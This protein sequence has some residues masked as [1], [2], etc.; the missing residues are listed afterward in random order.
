MGI[1]RGG[2]SFEV[3]VVLFCGGQGMR[4]REHSQTLPKP[5]V[6]IGDRPLL[7]HL[8]RY[9]AHYGHTEFVLCLG[10]Q[11]ATIRDYFLN[12]D[13]CMSN[14]FTLAPGGRHELHSSDVSDWSISFIDTGLNSNIGQRLLR[15]REYLHGESIFLANYADGLSD[16]PL[17][18]FLEE[19]SRGDAIAA[20]AAVQP[21]RPLAAVYADEAGYVSRIGSIRDGGTLINGGFFAMRPEIFE[22]LN[23]GEELLEQPFARLLAAGRLVAYRHHGFWQSLDTHRDKIIFDRMAAQ[24]ACPWAVW[25]R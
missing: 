24:G 15:A 17:D 20:F 25:R 23:E 14:D 1:G 22:F 16:L 6:R 13:E 9:Y 8:M 11:G 7:W 3:K 12:Y 5:L 21:P 10:Y 4:L 18:A 19:F 2:G